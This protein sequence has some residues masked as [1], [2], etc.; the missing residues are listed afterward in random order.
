MNDY[1]Q[2]ESMNDYRLETQDARRVMYMNERNCLC[3]VTNS[4]QEKEWDE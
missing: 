4:G 3:Y 2:G 1:Q